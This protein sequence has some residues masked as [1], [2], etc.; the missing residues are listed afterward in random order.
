MNDS[1]VSQAWTALNPTAN[2]RRRIGVRLFAH[3][4][5]HDTSLAAEWLALL[6]LS[7]LRT[8]AFAAASAVAVAA[9]PLAWLVGALI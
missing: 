4:E 1:D 3:L 5:A 6:R 9:V 8:I 2:Q 7:P